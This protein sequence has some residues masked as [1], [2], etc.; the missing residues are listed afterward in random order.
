MSCK[1]QKEMKLRLFL[2]ILVIQLSTQKQVD[3][4]ILKL[5]E[6]HTAT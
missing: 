6:T 3:Y 1:I 5:S 2:I 4:T